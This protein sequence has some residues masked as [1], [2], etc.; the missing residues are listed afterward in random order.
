RPL[1]AALPIFPTASV[2]PRAGARSDRRRASASGSNTGTVA[3]LSDPFT[4]P[5]AGPPAVP[6][7]R[8]VFGIV[9]LRPL[10]HKQDHGKVLVFFARG[11]NRMPRGTGCPVGAVGAARAVLAVVSVVGVP[12]PPQVTAP[13]RPHAVEDDSQNV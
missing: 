13:R 1:H 2:R 11:R 6:A 10:V 5:G 4:R 3:P 7:S 9:R 8:P 12:V